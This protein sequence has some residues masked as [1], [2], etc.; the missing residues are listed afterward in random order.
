MNMTLRLSSKL[1]E[2]FIMYRLVFLRLLNYYSYFSNS[3]FFAISLET[4]QKS[5][6]GNKS[7]F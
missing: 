5:Q 2:S 3:K 4:L 6:V 1:Q 7:M